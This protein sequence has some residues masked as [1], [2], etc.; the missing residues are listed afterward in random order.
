MNTLLDQVER[1]LFEESDL[2]LDRLQGAIQKLQRFDIDYSD[3]FIQEVQHQYWQLED[4]IV[5]DASFNLNKGLGVR[6]I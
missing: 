1:N 4:G 2:N 6:A 5:K 3:I